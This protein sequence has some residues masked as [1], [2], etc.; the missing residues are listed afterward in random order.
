MEPPAFDI[1]LS[2]NESDSVTPLIFVLSPGVD[3]MS[4]LYRFAEHKMISPENLKV[5]SL[6]QG[7]GP[8][9]EKYIQE[10]LRK[11]K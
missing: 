2:F 7:Q 6:G 10:V 5:V 4:D 8:I 1:G 11:S 9:A 3:P